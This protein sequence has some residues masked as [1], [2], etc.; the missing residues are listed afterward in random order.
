[1]TI[2][3]KNDHVASLSQKLRD[4]GCRVK[5]I[6]VEGRFHSSVHSNA[7]EKLTKLI[8]RSE[9]LR[10]PDAENIH[11]PVRSTVDSQII[12]QGSLA[13][14]ILENTLL[15]PADWYN[16]LKSSIRRLPDT[17]KTVALAGF[18]KHVPSSLA[19]ASSLQLLALSDLD[20]SLS[21][22]PFN[23]PTHGSDNVSKYPAH[24]IA[25]VGMAGRFPGADSVDEL[26]DLLLEGKVMA[27]P[28]P[29]ERLRLPQTGDYEHTKW[30]GNFLRDSDAFDHRFFKKSSREAIAW[31]PQQ[32]ILLEVIYQALEA[33][34]Y[35][36]P[37][38]TKEPEDYG[39]YIGACM[40][41]YYDNLSCH[42]ATAYATIGTS[43]CFISGCMSHYFGWTGPSL[44]IDTA[45]SSSLV[46]IN[47]AC[48]AIWSGECS[49]AVAGGTNVISS[50]FDYQNLSAAGFLSPLAS[51][52]HLTPRRTV[53]VEVKVLQW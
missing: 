8:Q 19:H 9:D 14:P 48:R 43:R 31:D 33:A 12:S 16:T 20:P 5:T 28:A 47:T 45:C 2:T 15:K 35:F 25:I 38:S 17:K 49:R 51:A 4:R 46:A 53:I 41:N 23:N 6:H 11:A 21:I 39:C 27:Q 3:L 30:W 44:T 32:R 18:G 42:P 1:M 50:P 34:G 26:W 37:S 13:R 40:N 36:G 7:A 24:S 52:S 22:L 10:F 29:V